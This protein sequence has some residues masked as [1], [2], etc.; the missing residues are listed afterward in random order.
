MQ[1]T[2]FTKEFYV[3]FYEKFYALM[4]NPNKELDGLEVIDFRNE[5]AK[6]LGR[7]SYIDSWSKEYEDKLCSYEDVI[8]CQ[9][10]RDEVNA[11]DTYWSAFAESPTEYINDNVIDLIVDDLKLKG[12]KESKRKMRKLNNILS[13]VT[14]LD[15]MHYMVDGSLAY[16]KWTGKQVYVRR[17]ATIPEAYGINTNTIS[18]PFTT[19]VNNYHGDRDPIVTIWYTANPQSGEQGSIV[20]VFRLSD[21][22]ELNINEFLVEPI[23]YEYYGTFL[24]GDT[25]G[26]DMDTYITLTSIYTPFADGPNGSKIPV[27]WRNDLESKHFEDMR[28]PWKG[29]LSFDDYLGGDS[30][31]FDD[32]EFSSFMKLIDSSLPPVDLET[33]ADKRYAYLETKLDRD[34]YVNNVPVFVYNRNHV[35]HNGTI[36][37]REKMSPLLYLIMANFYDAILKESLKAYSMKAFD[38]PDNIYIRRKSSNKV[39]T[40]SVE[41]EVAAT[42]EPKIYTS[43]EGSLHEDNPLLRAAKASDTRYK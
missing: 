7:N 3:E 19:L 42:I 6:Y 27:M 33:E 31:A 41:D 38:T 5:V 12:V 14:E 30:I 16:G 29:T 11:I 23:D 21:A 20:F 25:D 24:I 18:K 1:D 43:S 9:L 39:N 28:L 34:P 32:K 2:V 4:Q 8:R 35:A 36:A 26:I 17:L 37:N 22:K 40:L 10:T 13:S 15:K